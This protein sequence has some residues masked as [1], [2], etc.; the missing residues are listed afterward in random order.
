MREQRKV[1]FNDINPKDYAY[2][3]IVLMTLH[4]HKW[5]GSSITNG[6]LELSRFVEGSDD[7]YEFAPEAK[8]NWTKNDDVE[9][10]K[11]IDQ[12]FPPKKQ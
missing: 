9:F 5:E 6:E 1:N 4:I 10:W 2:F 7:Y 3:A 8:N 12:M 11:S